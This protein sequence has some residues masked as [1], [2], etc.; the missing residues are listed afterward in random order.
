MLPVVM[1]TWPNTS[2]TDRIMWSGSRG[3]RQEVYLNEKKNNNATDPQQ[4]HSRVLTA[5]RW[6]EG[7]EL[8][9]RWLTGDAG[10]CD[11][12]G[13]RWEEPEDT[14][15]RLRL[16]EGRKLDERQRNLGETF[17]VTNM[18]SLLG[19]W[20]KFGLKEQK[21][22]RLLGRLIIIKFPVMVTISKTNN[23]D[24]GCFPLLR[25]KSK[26]SDILKISVNPKTKNN[27]N[28]TAQGDCKP[29]PMQLN[30]LKQTLL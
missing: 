26:S 28:W 1:V 27:N 29:L 19:R 15:Q 22:K 8:R 11:D 17:T 2:D 5:S 16:S 23:A 9:G 13:L 14:G 6:H 20:K 10:S 25:L 4:H 30:P 24:W 21:S 18:L 7:E 12:G 3:E